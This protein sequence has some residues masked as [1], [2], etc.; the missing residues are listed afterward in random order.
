MRL[1]RLLTI[2][3][4]SLVAFP[5]TA[6]M[7]KCTAKDGTVLYQ[8]RPCGDAAREATLANGMVA[9]GDVR[10]TMNGKAVPGQT[11]ERAVLERDLAQ[12]RARCGVYRDNID[13]YKALLDS[14]N[15]VTRSHAE[16]DIRQQE[17]R[18]KDDNCAAL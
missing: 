7:Y 3:F 16:N 9:D 13:R 5:A 2:A 4:A 12:R 17:R 15:D 14:P 8:A 18:M 6:Q 10:A 1:L 11:L